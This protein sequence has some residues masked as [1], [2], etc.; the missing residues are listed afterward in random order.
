MAWLF[1]KSHAKS[2]PV[3]KQDKAKA[4]CF[5]YFLM[6]FKSAMLSKLSTVPIMSAWVRVVHIASVGI[7]FV[8]TA[9]G[10]GDAAFTMP[11]VMCMESSPWLA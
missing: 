5:P 9:I 11:A 2:L 10:A 3:I 7:G 1:G 6:Y 4:T 8:V